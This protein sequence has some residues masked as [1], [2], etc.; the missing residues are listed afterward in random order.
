MFV[1]GLL[2]SE[3]YALAVLRGRPRG[4][5]VAERVPALLGLRARP[6]DLL[7]SEGAP[8]FSFILDEAVITA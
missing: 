2:Q 5:I 7:S 1:P 4:G 8:P 3:E 6:Q